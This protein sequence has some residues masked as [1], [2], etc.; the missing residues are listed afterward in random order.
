MITELIKGYNDP[1]EA[2]FVKQLAMK[3]VA[4]PSEIAHGVLFLL[5]EDASFVTGSALAVDGGRCYH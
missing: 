3:R 1:T 2:P 5:S 4:D